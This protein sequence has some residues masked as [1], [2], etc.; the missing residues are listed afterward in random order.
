VWVRL[1]PNQCVR[2]RVGGVLGGVVH[3]GMQESVLLLALLKCSR[4]RCC[5]VKQPPYRGE[6]GGP[7]YSRHFT[8]MYGTFGRGGGCDG[9]TVE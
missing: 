5:M 3:V 1:R 8:C 7:M 6:T 9:R 4:T 2:C